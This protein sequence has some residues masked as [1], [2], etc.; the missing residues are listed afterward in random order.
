MGYFV[1]EADEVRIRDD[2]GRTL[3]AMVVG[4]DHASGLALVRSVAPFDAA[5]LRLGDSAA[6]AESDPVLVVNYGGRSDV[7][8]AHVVSRRSFT[9]NW[10]YLL[11]PAIFTSP[12]TLNWSGAALIGKDRS[13][14]GVGSLNLRDA[15]AAGPHLPRIMF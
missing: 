4:Y 10:G 2:R 8:L 9:G 5:P 11:D 14:L 13:L 6:L 3:P 7:T 15:T 1:I 12:P